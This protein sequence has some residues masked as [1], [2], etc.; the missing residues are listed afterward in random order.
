MI[1]SRS[2]HQ[3]ECNLICETVPIL[4]ETSFVSK[5]TSEAD[6]G[7]D[8][9]CCVASMPSLRCDL[10]AG[11]DRLCLAEPFPGKGKGAA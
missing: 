2:S 11:E 4:R 1:R 10:N 8:S 6:L 9:Q 5:A 7:A 3:R